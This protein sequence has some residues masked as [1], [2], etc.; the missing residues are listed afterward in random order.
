[1]AGVTFLDS[2]KRETPQDHPGLALAVCV[3]FLF[4]VQKNREKNDR[5]TQK[6]TDD[7]VLCPV[8]RAA[9]LVKRIRRLVPDIGAL[10]LILQ[11]LPQS[12]PVLTNL[13]KDL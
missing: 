8:R 2:D 13:A 12:T 7:P 9:S 1:M 10:S 4:A 3:T 11:A 6:R 5:R